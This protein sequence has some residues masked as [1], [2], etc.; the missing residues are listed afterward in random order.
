M[1]K[2]RRFDGLVKRIVMPVLEPRGFLFS[3]GGFSLVKDSLIYLVLF[4]PDLKHG[5]TFRI[6]VGLNSSLL[7]D[8]DAPPT[9]IGTYITKYLNHSGLG[10]SPSNWPSFDD[11]KTSE[12]LLKAASLIEDCVLPWFSEF[13]TLSSMAEALPNEYDGLKGKLFLKDGQNALALQELLNYR[14][15][16]LAMPASGDVITALKEVDELIQICK[17]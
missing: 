8:S 14:L 17:T 3:E 11:K 6:I 16:L 1:T 5:R 12:S 7:A 15:R 10:N 13:K 4:D 2:L 9:E